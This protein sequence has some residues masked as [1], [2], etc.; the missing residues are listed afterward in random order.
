MPHARPSDIS[1][2]PEITAVR[3]PH[4]FGRVGRKPTSGDCQ[5]TDSAPR[6]TSASP[7]LHC[8]GRGPLRVKVPTNDQPVKTTRDWYAHE[9]SSTESQ[10]TAVDCDRR[11]V[12]RPAVHH[13]VADGG[14]QSAAAHLSKK[15]DDL[16]EGGRDAAHLFC[17]PCSIDQR[18]PVIVFGSEPR[19]RADAVHL[20]LHAP[21][22][23][24]AVGHGKKTS[25]KLSCSSC[26]R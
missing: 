5:Q 7:L 11:A 3:F 12:V 19:T 6:A 10:H 13:A 20:P 1:R 4:P 25:W 21:L 24:F 18:L 9:T 26:R 2:N 8:S 23:P 16:V 17:P 14:G 15:R 22:E